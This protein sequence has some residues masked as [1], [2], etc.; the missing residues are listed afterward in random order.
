[1]YRYLQYVLEYVQYLQQAFT[2][3]TITISRPELKKRNASPG[4][5]IT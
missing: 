4:T 3:R 5:N 2:T 1:M